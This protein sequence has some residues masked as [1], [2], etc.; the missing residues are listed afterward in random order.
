MSRPASELEQHVRQIMKAANRGTTLIAQLLA[1]S[2]KQVMW[3]R[4]IDVNS[5]LIDVDKILHRLITENIYLT[6]LLGPETGCVKVDPG[7]VEQ[8]VINLVVN[9]RD[10]MP[11]GGELRVETECASARSRRSG[12]AWRRSPA[13]TLCCRS[14]TPAPG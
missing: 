4:V 11:E 14:A 3:P 8:V 6:L 1:F 7:Q 12:A 13:N 2:R 5:A 10:A 9:A